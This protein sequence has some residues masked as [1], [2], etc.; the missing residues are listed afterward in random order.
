MISY[1]HNEPETDAEIAQFLRDKLEDSEWPYR[2]RYCSRSCNCFEGY[3]CAI[4]DAEKGEN[5]K[6]GCTAAATLER[7]EAFVQKQA[8]LEEKRREEEE[9][10]SCSAD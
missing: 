5:H 3:E 6:P 2:A 10:A 7:I 4:C 1:V 9:A 8:E